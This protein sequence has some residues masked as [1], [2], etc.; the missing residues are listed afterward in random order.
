MANK[1]IDAFASD[2]TYAALISL[3]ESTRRQSVSAKESGAYPFVFPQGS[4]YIQPVVFQTACQ[5]RLG[6]PITAMGDTSGVKCNCKGHK[7]IDKHGY[8]FDSCKI[9]EEIHSRHNEIVR[10]VQALCIQAGIKTIRE[11]RGCFAVSTD[12]QLRP[13]LRLSRPGALVGIRNCQQDIVVDIR[14]TD[15]LCSSNISTDSIKRSEQDKYRTYQQ[16]S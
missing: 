8:H 6:L 1:F 16:H 2:E 11:P 12:Q 15:P 10:N 4:T 7:S 5:Y 14:I 13:D 3:I 9:G